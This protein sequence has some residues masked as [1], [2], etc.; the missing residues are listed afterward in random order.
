ML[1][2]MGV[3]SISMLLSAIASHLNYIGDA[4]VHRN[5]LQKEYNEL[6]RKK[7]KDDRPEMM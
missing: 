3:L 5:M 6:L 4:M 2:M 1:M 7:F